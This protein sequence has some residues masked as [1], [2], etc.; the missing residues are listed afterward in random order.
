[1]S[2]APTVSRDD[3]IAFVIQHTEKPHNRGEMPDATVSYTGGNPGCGD[4]VTMYLKIGDDERIEDVSF[5]AEGCT[6]SR[7]GASWITDLVKGKRVDE[8]EAMEYQP[9]METFGRDV[10]ATRP[11]C[12]TLGFSTVKT[13]VKKYRDD[14]RRAVLAGD[15]ESA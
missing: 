5:T 7:A 2:D 11:R 14:Y 8:V 6:I 13:A 4:I 12:A 3:L 1:M 15:T 9:I 10:M